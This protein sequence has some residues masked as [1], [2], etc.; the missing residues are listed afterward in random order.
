M[1][2]H[3]ERVAAGPPS[4]LRLRDS[5]A[6]SHCSTQNQHG[7]Q[8][9]EDGGKEDFLTNSEVRHPL[10]VMLCKRDTHKVT[11]YLYSVKF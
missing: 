10:E 4:L 7:L 2:R 8:E 1:V 9:V 3:E 6:P 11:S 5:K